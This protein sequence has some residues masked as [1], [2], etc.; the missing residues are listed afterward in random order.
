MVLHSVPP[1]LVFV[2]A[3]AV[4]DLRDKL[5]DAVTAAV[6]ATGP[7]AVGRPET[8]E[9]VPAPAETHPRG[10]GGTETGTG[11]VSGSQRL[12]QRPRLHVEV[13][14]LLR[15]DCQLGSSAC[16]LT[17]WILDVRWR[18]GVCRKR[19]RCG[20]APG[21]YGAAPGRYV[22]APALESAWGIAGVSPPDGNA[23]HPAGGLFPQC[24][25]ETPRRSPHFRN[26]H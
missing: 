26:E 21:R 1:L 8:S 10:S 2:A 13:R 3:E 6:T 12:R 25:G 4:T 16:L 5:T 20:A 11:A 7:V 14:D 17:G 23:I 9:D 22:A 15:V 19:C 24:P 18:G